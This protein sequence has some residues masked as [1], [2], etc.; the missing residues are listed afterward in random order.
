[1]QYLNGCPPDIIGG[2]PHADDD[3]NDDTRRHRVGSGSQ[4]VRPIGKASGRVRVAID[5]VI[6]PGRRRRRLVV[7]NAAMMRTAQP[8]PQSEGGRRRD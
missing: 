8:Q 1:M 7:P 2:G 5:K 6:R 4:R 3:L